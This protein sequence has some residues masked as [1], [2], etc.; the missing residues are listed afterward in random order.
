VSESTA[1]LDSTIAAFAAAVRRH[2][3]DLPLEEVDDLTGGLE[4]DLS[5]QASDEGGTLSLDDPAAYAAELRASAGLPPRGEADM[6][7]SQRIARGLDSLGTEARRVAR[8]T[9]LGSW[10]CDIVVS[11]RPVWWVT[12][13]WVVYQLLTIL[14]LG[15]S[16]LVPSDLVLW[17]L[18]LAVLV[19]SVQWGRG[20]W[21]ARRVLKGLRLILSVIAI[22]TL[23]FFAWWALNEANEA[24][25]DDNSAY[26]TDPIGLWLDGQRVTNIFGYDADG[27]PVTDIQLFDQNGDPLVTVGDPFVDEEYD[28]TTDGTTATVPFEG[29]T[30]GT[31]WNIYPLNEAPLSD[32]G[33]ADPRDAVP[34]TPPFRTTNPIPKSSTPTPTPT[35]T[36]EPTGAPSGA[37]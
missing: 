21:A 17:V 35:P 37:Q 13:G 5:E 7:L 10:L 1:T 14:L 25:A 4:A 30:S 20:K 28:Y 24:A 34:A 18:L 8:S 19:L 32:R 9:R 22:V 11:L 23:P 31:G 3:N 15:H 6:P 27:N 2:L 12:R 16:T 33:D 26:S 36:P 29:S